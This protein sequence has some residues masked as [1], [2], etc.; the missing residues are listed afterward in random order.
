[1]FYYLL[2]KNVNI[3]KNI[4][5]VASITVIKYMA[6]ILLG[7]II[8]RTYLE[9]GFLTPF[10]IAMFIFDLLFSLMHH[11]N[12]STKENDVFWDD[13]VIQSDF[14]LGAYNEEVNNMRSQFGKRNPRHTTIEKP[15]DLGNSNFNFTNKESEK[16][17]SDEFDTDDLEGAIKK[18][19]SDSKNEGIPDTEDSI[20]TI[21]S[22]NKSKS[23]KH[24]VNIFSNCDD[25][26]FVK[27]DENSVTID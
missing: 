22:S 7:K 13:D 1:M 8:E 19:L 27:S 5:Q 25:D 20:D 26:L 9:P 16:S 11:Y 21:E 17:E 18:I 4:E 24:D 14:S 23:I 6:F 12:I 3:S 15:F 10:F 2:A